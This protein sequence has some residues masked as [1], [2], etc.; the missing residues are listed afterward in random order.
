MDHAYLETGCSCIAQMYAGLAQWSGSSCRDC[1]L[2]QVLLHA[3][4]TATWHMYRNIHNDIVYS[5][6]YMH[7]VIY[8]LQSTMALHITFDDFIHTIKNKMQYWD[9]RLYMMVY[10]IAMEDIMCTCTLI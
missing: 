4:S 7:P 3:L 5:A 2:Y 8:S 9:N 1:L 6:M 10:I